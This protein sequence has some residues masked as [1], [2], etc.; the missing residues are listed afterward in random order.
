MAEHYDPWTY[1]DPWQQGDEPEVHTEQAYESYYPRRSS[2][3]RT[4]AQHDDG[5]HGREH[6]WRILHDSPPSC[7]GKIPEKQAEPYLKLLAGWLAITKT[8]RTQRGLVLLQYSDGDLKLL[9]K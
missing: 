1:G 6:G 8:L 4:Y 9:I 3:S 2:S 5:D 7:D